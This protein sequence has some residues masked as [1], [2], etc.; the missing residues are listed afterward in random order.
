MSN[1][2]TKIRSKLSLAELMLAKLSNVVPISYSGGTL[3]EVS[4]ETITPQSFSSLIIESE[5]KIKRLS[6]LTPIAATG[7]LVEI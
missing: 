3:V 5:D 7:G 1:L 6:R 4:I 2:Q